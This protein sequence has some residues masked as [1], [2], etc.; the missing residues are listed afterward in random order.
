M[1]DTLP[2]APPAVAP[3]LL[4]SATR[5]SAK[6]IAGA[7]QVEAN[8]EAE[9]PLLFQTLLQLLVTYLPPYANR[10]RELRELLLQLLETMLD[11]AFGTRDACVKCVVEALAGLPTGEQPGGCSG[12]IYLPDSILFLVDLMFMAAMSRLGTCTVPYQAGYNDARWGSPRA[13]AG[14]RGLCCHVL[15]HE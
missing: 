10:G 15:Q 5:M 9:H 3:Q 1:V 6:Q 11:R 4:A 13:G 12:L 8:S 14:N 2:L 7:L